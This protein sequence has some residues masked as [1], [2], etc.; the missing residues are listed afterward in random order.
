MVAL[1]LLAMIPRV[2]VSGSVECAGWLSS[3]TPDRSQ[4]GETLLIVSGTWVSYA[5][6][7]IHIIARAMSRSKPVDVSLNFAN[8]R[9]SY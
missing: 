2:S 6:C 8:A 9:R 5:S 4:N 7:D 1:P 3:L